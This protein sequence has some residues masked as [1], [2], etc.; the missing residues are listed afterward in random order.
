LPGTG[1]K[2]WSSWPISASWVARITGVSHWHQAPPGSFE[3]S[4]H[5]CQKSVEERD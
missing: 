1:L 4:W 5:S 3:W 2:L